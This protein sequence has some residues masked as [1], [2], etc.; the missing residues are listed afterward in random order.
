[1]LFIQWTDHLKHLTQ[2][3]ERLRQ[4]GLTAKPSK[5][6]WAAA[7]CLYL[8]HVV[9]SGKVPPEESKGKAI[10]EFAYP[11]TKTDVRFLWV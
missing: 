9:G 11:I 4:V 7:Y 3:L 2:A 8:G 10:L 6:E 5:C 1:M